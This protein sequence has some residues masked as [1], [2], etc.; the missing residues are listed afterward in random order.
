MDLQGVGPLRKKKAARTTFVTAYTLE[1]LDCK[2]V[3]RGVVN[4][5]EQ[6]LRKVQTG[7]YTV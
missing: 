7:S 5:R 4:G 3:R 6:R 1:G 2:A